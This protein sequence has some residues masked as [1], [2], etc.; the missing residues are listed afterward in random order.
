MTDSPRTSQAPESDPKHPLKVGDVA[1]DFEAR[2]SSGAT[3]QLSSF[4]GKRN[5][6]LYF[7]PRDN[8][9][10]CTTEAC[11]FRDLYP[12]L[13]DA[14]VIGISTDDDESHR[15]FAGKYALPF[16]LVSDPQRRIARLYG[17]SRSLLGVFQRTARVTY[18]I[19]KLGVI[20]E[21]IASEL[22]MSVHFERAREALAKLDAAQT[23]PTVPND[24]PVQRTD[25]E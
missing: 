24:P 11:G 7:Y 5:V 3:I 6:V 15:G 21:V 22:R 12:R 8:T 20:A 2:A 17:A 25:A 14:E 9:P 1:P 16:P 10:G 18:V 19:D 13:G 4:R 23:S